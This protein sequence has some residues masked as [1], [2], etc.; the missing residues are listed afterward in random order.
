MFSLPRPGVE[1]ISPALSGRFLTT[2]QPGESPITF[3]IL[4]HFFTLSI[5]YCFPFSWHKITKHRITI[6]SSNSIPWYKPK[7]IEKRVSNRYVHSNVAHN[8][9]NLET[10]WVSID[11]WMYNKMWHILA[12]EYYI[13]LKRK[14]TI[15]HA[16][17]MDELWGHHSEWTQP[18]TKRLWGTRM[19]DL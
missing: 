2:G 17:N 16:S 9:Q 15:S 6:W 18:V 3:Y 19:K 11:G 5:T 4:K 14:E 12:M 8:N 1:S 10:T 13:T 7:T